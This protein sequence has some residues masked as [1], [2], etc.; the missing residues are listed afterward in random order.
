[1]KFDS[2]IYWEKG[3]RRNNQD[4]LALAQVRTTRGRVLFAVV[5]DGIGGLEE[6]E[7]AS[8][9][10]TEQLTALFYE[11]LLLLIRK[12]KG[13]RKLEKCLIR[14]LY[15]IRGALSKY[16]AEHEIRLGATVSLLLIWKNKYLLLHLG[17]SRIY[18][19]GKKRI[20]QLTKDHS[21]G[22]N[23][24]FKCLS[25]FPFQMPDRAWGRLY[26][27]CSF[28]LCTDGFYRKMDREKFERLL[29]TEIDSEQQIERRLRDIADTCQ[30]K[31]EG[32]NMT[33]VY[34]KVQR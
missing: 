5:S 2:G 31:G 4:S 9:Y 7:T 25:S 8:G 16:A 32:D 18:Y 26:G 34:V 27:K 21:D 22:K 30:K 1:M 6:G 20:R 13:R 24:L 10:I 12:K 17:D 11:Q 14:C 33:A 28:L 3:R 19:F 15:Q 23:G 29:P